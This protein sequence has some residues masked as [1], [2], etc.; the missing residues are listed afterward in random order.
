MVRILAERG[1]VDRSS[2]FVVPG[3]IAQQ[4]F[5]Q[6]APLLVAHVIQLCIYTR[7]PLNHSSESFL[8]HDGGT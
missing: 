8:W 5:F 7:Y 4:P 2:V 6:V 1:K 3:R